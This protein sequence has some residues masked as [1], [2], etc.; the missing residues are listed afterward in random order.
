[1]N[2]GVEIDGTLPDDINVSFLQE[3]VETG[4]AVR[5]GAMDLLARNLRSRN[6]VS[7]GGSRAW[8]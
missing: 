1:M 2:L 6:D 5:M 7:A 4:V 8:T 3:Q